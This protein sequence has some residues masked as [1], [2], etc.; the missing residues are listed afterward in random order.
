M[1]QVDASTDDSAGSDDGSPQEAMKHVKKVID[2]LKAHPACFS[3]SWELKHA[4]I[5]VRK[6]GQKRSQAF[7]LASISA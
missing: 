6:R 4:R 2:S 3:A 5:L 1:Q 7:P